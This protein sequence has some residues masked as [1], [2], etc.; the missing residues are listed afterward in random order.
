MKHYDT[1][2]GTTLPQTEYLYGTTDIPDVPKH[3]I[4]N[5]LTLL[6]DMLTK[7]NTKHYMVRDTIRIGRVQQA[8]KFWSTLN[9]N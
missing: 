7:L 8:I 3:I 5:R 1:F 9:D 2:A 6:N 4:D